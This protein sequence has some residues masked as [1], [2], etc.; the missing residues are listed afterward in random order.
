VVAVAT[1]NLRP[2]VPKP[3]PKPW[4]KLIKECWNDNHEERPNFADLIPKLEELIMPEGNVE[5]DDQAV[6]VKPL[7]K[8][9]IN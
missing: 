2:I 1:N 8:S 7:H 6:M 4:K 5:F 3:V 9:T